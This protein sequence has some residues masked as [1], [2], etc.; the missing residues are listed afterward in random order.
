MSKIVAL[1][2]MFLVVFIQNVNGQHLIQNNIEPIPRHFKRLNRMFEEYYD[3]PVEGNVESF[4]TVGQQWPLWSRRHLIN[5][6]EDKGSYKKR[7]FD[8]IDRAA[9]GGLKKRNFDK[10]DMAAFS[11]LKKRE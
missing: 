7:T 4:L 6:V 8:E 2:F 5:N 11:G 10:I 9:F 3:T 1:S